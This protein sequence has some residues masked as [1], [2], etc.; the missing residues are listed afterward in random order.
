MPWKLCLRKPAKMKH[1]RRASN[2]ASAVSSFPAV[3]SSRNSLVSIRVLWLA[4][5][6]V[7]SNSSTP[8]RS[9]EAWRKSWVIMGRQATGAVAMILAILIAWSALR[10]QT[11]SALKGWPFFLPPASATRRGCSACPG[12][13]SLVRN[14]LGGIRRR[15]PCLT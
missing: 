2:I 10:V 15:T 12:G 13:D 7:S 11:F 14:P 8:S 5:P 3:N 6:L 1:S 4:R 9:T